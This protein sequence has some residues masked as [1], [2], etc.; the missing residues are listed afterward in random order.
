MTIQGTPWVVGT[1]PDGQDECQSVWTNQPDAINAEIAGRICVPEHAA[2]LAA[3]PDLLAALEALVTVITAPPITGMTEIAQAAKKTIA[4]TEQA[5]AAITKARPPTIPER[6][7]A[8][9][10]MPTNVPGETVGSLLADLNQGAESIKARD[11]IRRLLEWG[12]LTGGWE[13]PIWD[14]ARA[15]LASDEPEH[16]EPPLRPDELGD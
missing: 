14:E 12:S 11:L 15:F 10:A 1:D 13:S 9:H 8:I 3:A 7:E 5:R 6:I 2:L 16:A 4:A